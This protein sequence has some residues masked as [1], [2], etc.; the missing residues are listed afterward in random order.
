MAKKKNE[1]FDWLKALLIAFG[2]AFI[3]RMF[4]SLLLW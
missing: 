2:L 3:V 1:W 4:F